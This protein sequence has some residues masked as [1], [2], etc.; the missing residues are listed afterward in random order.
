M[1]SLRFDTANPFPLVPIDGDNY[2]QAKAHAGQVDD[3]LGLRIDATEASLD[4]RTWKDLPIQSLLTPY[5]ELRE[6]LS[7]LN[8]R[9]SQTVIDLGC[10]YGRMAHVLHRH[11]PGVAFIGYELEEARVREGQRVLP[12]DPGLR[13]LTQDLSLA[14]FK[15]PPAAAYFI[16]DFG[17]S[18]AVEKIL[19]DLRELA[20]SAPVTVIARGRLTRALIHRDHAWLAEVVPPEHAAHFSI[21][22]S[23]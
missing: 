12:A 7:R 3:W 13:L 2:A 15:P 18:E 17:P 5:A 20:T 4:P 10:A 6:M 22:R 14:S 11:H 23:A 19:N 21:Y 16:Y 9:A 1:S 8:P